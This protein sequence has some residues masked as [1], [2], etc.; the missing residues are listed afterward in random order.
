MT[1]PADFAPSAENLLLAAR[2]NPVN[3][4]LLRRL[5]ALGLPQGFLT[6]GSLFQAVWN[7]LSGR[8]AAA[9]VR[10]Y[11]VFYF[12][13]SDLSWE[14]E[15]RV[16]RR[17]AEATADLLPPSDAAPVAS[18]AAPMPGAPISAAPLSGAPLPAA[19]VEVR[20]QAR[21]HLWYRDRFGSDYPRLGCATDGIDRYLIPCT[22]V[23]ISLETGAL[24]APDGFHDLWAGV[25]RPNPLL[26]DLPLFRRKAESYRARWSWLRVVEAVDGA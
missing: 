5:P 17:V 2:E 18:R 14:A 24:Y 8:P 6:A 21:V 1:E 13:S 26:P 23:G 7:R 9:G 22:S 16:I 12:D 3:A 15:D 11:D 20:N 25:L 4:A 10:D 19:P